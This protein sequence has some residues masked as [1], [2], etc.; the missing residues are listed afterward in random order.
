[1]PSRAAKLRT[2][3]QFPC[4]PLTVLALSPNM[5]EFGQAPIIHIVCCLS[6]TFVLLLLG[7]R[8]RDRSRRPYF[9]PEALFALSLTD[10]VPRE[11]YSP[12]PRSPE[13][14]P[15]SPENGPDMVRDAEDILRM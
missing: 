2:L 1:M 8:P 5:G 12:G 14:G 10:R 3:V 13:H 15:R 4:A 6:E 9:L 11:I 7:P